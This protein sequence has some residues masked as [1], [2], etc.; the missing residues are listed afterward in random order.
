MVGRNGLIRGVARGATLLT[1]GTVGQ[2]DC[3]L[4]SHEL[5]A[6][7]S[8]KV[9]CIVWGNAHDILESTLLIIVTPDPL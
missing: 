7:P 6:I 9:A 1:E 8:V 5:Q 3:S 2:D 4:I